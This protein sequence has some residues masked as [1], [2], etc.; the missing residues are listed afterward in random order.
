MCG[1]YHFSFDLMDEVAGLVEGTDWK[2]ELGLMDKDIHPGEVAPVITVRTEAAYGGEYQKGAPE[3]QNHRQENGAP[4][5]QDHRQGTGGPGLQIRRQR[6]GF[7]G[8]GGKGLVF[9]ARSESVT[10][11]PMFREG[12]ARRRVAVPVSWFYEW[13]KSKEKYTFTREGSRV[14]FLAG[15][16]NRYQDGEHFV[17]LTTE[18]NSSMAPVHSRMPLILDKDQVRD[19]IL[20][21]DR[22]RE[23]LGQ[24]PPE[25]LKSCEYEQQTLF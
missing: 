15:F 6:W 25:L 12:V 18:A 19:W 1:R 10:E 11:K 20:D 2:L 3:I 21:S 8:P 13:N 17:I 24:V 7:P 14:L 23:L 5:I 9:N 4:E 22:T 16:Y